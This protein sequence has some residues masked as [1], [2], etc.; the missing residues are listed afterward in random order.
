MKNLFAINERNIKMLNL[1]LLVVGA[2]VLI[3]LPIFMSSFLIFQTTQIMIYVIA[4]MGLNLL[5]GFSGQLSLGHGAFFAVGAYSAGILMNS[6]EIH[7]SIAIVTAGLIAFLFGIMFG[8]PALRLEGHY[9]AMATFALAV[10]MPQIIKLSIFEDLTGGSQGMAIQKPSLTIGSLS[11]DQLLYYI[12]LICTICLYWVAQNLIHSRTGRA[13]LAIK[14][15]A[16]S[17]KTM[18][19]N[20]A[21]Y[22]TM[23][24]GVSAAFNGIAGALSA[25]A[26]QYIAPES[27]TFYLSAAILVGL[28]VGGVGWIAGA[29]WGA[30]FVLLIPNAAETVS[31]ELAGAMYGFFLIAL[32]FFL[33]NGVST[34]RDYFNF[35]GLKQ[36]FN[37]KPLKE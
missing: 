10:A 28:V 26:V 16:T 13:W 33:P 29:I 18:G 27:Y 31:K 12:T 24:F 37:K 21:F 15:N 23:A 9:L 3:I 25:M 7:Y 32:V 20:I 11:D 19:I 5:V 36:T 22:K 6:F 30:I 14:E 34:L 17:A 4:I 2:L 8:I 35:V 1:V